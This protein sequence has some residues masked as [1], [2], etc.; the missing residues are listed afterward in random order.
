[1]SSHNQVN[2]LSE[3]D[4]QG[5]SCYQINHPLFSA[6]VSKFGG[7]LLNFSGKD[8]QPLIWLSPLAVTDGSKAI[9]GGSPICWPWFGAAPEAYKGESQHGYARNTYWQLE[10]L[11]Q[12]SAQCTLTLVPTEPEFFHQKF[13]L[14]VKLIY[15]FAEDAKVSVE[16]TNIGQQDFTLTAAIHS[17]FNLVDVGQISIPELNQHSYFDKLLN[18][19]ARQEQPLQINQAIDRIYHYQKP[20]LSLCSNADRL[21]LKHSGHDSIVVWNP[22]QQDAKAMSDFPDLGYQSMLCVEAAITQGLIL[23]PGETHLLSQA[24]SRDQRFK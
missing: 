22:W 10:Q 9:R 18:A 16:T 11:Q 21:R 3:Q 15:Q 19:S 24:F 20:E 14:A 23:K 8:Q 1:M 2:Y 4:I 13:G 17:Y 7:Q 6:T 12:S 5:L